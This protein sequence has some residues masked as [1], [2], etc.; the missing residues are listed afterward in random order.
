MP[1]A[2]VCI[3]P[4]L[5]TTGGP[6]SFQS[7]L[8]AGLAI[9]DIETHHELSRSD[10]RALL[11]TGATRSFGSLIE[12]RRRGIRIVQRLDG[13]NWLHKKRSTGLRHYLRSER[14]NLQLAIIRRYFADRIVYQSEFTRD[15]WSRVYGKIN[16]PSSTIYNG[17]DLNI[18]NLP[19]RFS[20]PEEL[21][22]ILVVE[23]SFQGGHERDLLNA[24]GFA[25]GLAKYIGKKVEL[26]IAGNI[27][28]NLRNHL[29]SGDSVK[30]NWVGVIPHEQIPDL[31]RSA[32]LFFPAE[33]NAACPN[34]VVEAL[35][36]GLPVVGYATGSISE[37]VGEEGGAAAP[38]GSDYWNLKPPV[39]ES[40]VHAASD[41]L[42][43]LPQFRKS[44]RKR[45][46]TLFSLDRMVEAYQEI[47]LGD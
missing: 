40:L 11:I 37:L 30:I 20:P 8:K 38:Y 46:E 24:V 43:N 6:S 3:L 17:V 13:M 2:S 25:E 19:S 15:W 31:D 28:E 26:V 14:M 10:T 42:E 45:A 33:I 47:L 22:R 41:I 27:P 16:K 9:R 29:I 12:A 36:S 21:I 35:A 18:F 32:H 1:K 5:K 39:S 7:K 34:S 23:G 44:A 4:Q